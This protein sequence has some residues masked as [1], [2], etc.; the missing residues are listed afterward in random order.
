MIVAKMSPLS[1]DKFRAERDA[2]LPDDQILFTVAYAA[3]MMWAVKKGIERVL[4]PDAVESTVDAIR[5]P[6]AK[7]CWYSQ[8][9]FEKIFEKMQD[10]MPTAFGRVA[11]GDCPYPLADMLT[12]VDLAGYQLSHSVGLDLRFGIYF[13][14]LV[15]ET[16][17]ASR[18]TAE[19]YHKKT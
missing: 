18:K 3:C 1:S 7:Q 11:D 5:Y 6:L 10:V 14:L 19:D 2:L 9:V 17:G 8:L 16:F 12:A 13:A 15:A 4:T